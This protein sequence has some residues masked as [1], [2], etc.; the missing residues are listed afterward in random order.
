[1]YKIYLKI[2][3]KLTFT[4][5][6]VLILTRMQSCARGGGFVLTHA[7]MKITRA[8][9]LAELSSVVKVIVLTRREEQSIFS[10]PCSQTT[11][12]LTVMAYNHYSMN[13]AIFS[14]PCRRTTNTLTITAYSPYSASLAILSVPYGRTTI[15]FDD[16]GLQSLPGEVNRPPY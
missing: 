16:K 15:V 3:T 13:L 12:K 2:T 10:T 8:A 11:N 5:C 7:V 6:H 14:S 1:M 4:S 9:W